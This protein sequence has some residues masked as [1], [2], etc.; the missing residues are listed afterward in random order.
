VA[1]RADIAARTARTYL[2]EVVLQSLVG[3]VDTDLLEAIGLEVLKA[4]DI[5]MTCHGLETAA[6]PAGTCTHLPRIAM[7]R[8]P[9]SSSG[10]N[11]ASISP[12]N[13][14]KELPK[15]A[16]TVASTAFCAYAHK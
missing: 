4:K 7:P 6:P 15:M 2:V 3:K 12:T 9:S 13:H 5:Y 11:I 1:L 16:L 8:V 14:S 10:L